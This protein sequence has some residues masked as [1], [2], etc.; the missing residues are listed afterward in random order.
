MPEEPYRKGEELL[1]AYSRQRHA[2]ARK[3]TEMPTSIRNLLQ[4][5]IR[6]QFSKEPGRSGVDW[7][8]AHAWWL[9]LA[10]GSCVLTL[11]TFG[12]FF[13]IIPPNS[14]RKEMLI[15]LRHPEAQRHIFQ[16]QQGQGQS[17]E[18]PQAIQPVVLKA[19]SPTVVRPPGGTASLLPVS[20]NSTSTP[21]KEETGFVSKIRS[22]QNPTSESSRKSG[23]VA[24]QTQGLSPGA[25]QENL[26]ALNEIPNR[27][28]YHF[29]GVPPTILE[30]TGPRATASKNRSVD[31]ISS[32]QSLNQLL[33]IFSVETIGG[34]IRVIDSD[35]SVYAGR[36]GIVAGTDEGA[37][38]AKGTNLTTHREVSLTGSLKIN[39]PATI[40][41]S[42]GRSPEP[43]KTN[44]KSA[45]RGAEF[46]AI[47]RIGT[48]QFQINAVS[49]PLP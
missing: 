48:N 16:T 39:P 38:Q 27:R 36:I 21:S 37:F 2:D 35:N 33:Q 3:V 9:R 32:G 41:L 30:K 10:W 34:H 17:K 43:S 8:A 4:A 6:K 26:P 24:L 31:F 18:L 13:L 47:A 22:N 12:L 23:V 46:R 20:A 40:P 7:R 42:R 11:I 44:L 14:E 15:A 49:T 19:D 1:Q 45:L 5:E 28:L 29:T 25:L